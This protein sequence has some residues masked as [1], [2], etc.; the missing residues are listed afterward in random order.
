MSNEANREEDD[1]QIQPNRRAG[2]DPVTL[3]GPYLTQNDAA[4]V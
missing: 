2:E 4:T 3:Q 1:K